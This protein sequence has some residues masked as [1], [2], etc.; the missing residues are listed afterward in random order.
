MILF[1]F[2]NPAFIYL[3]SHIFEKEGPA[4]TS[5]RLIYIFAGAVLSTTA[6]I[7]QFF[8]STKIVGQ[9]V[10]YVFMLLPVFS[11]TYG[12]LEVAYIDFFANMTGTPPKAPLSFEAAGV[13]LPYLGGTIVIYML[14]TILIDKGVICSGNRQLRLEQ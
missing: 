14:L 4:G 2:A 10:S 6:I 7:L 5:I 9:I 13:T 3:W 11:L 8:E 12:L 1:S